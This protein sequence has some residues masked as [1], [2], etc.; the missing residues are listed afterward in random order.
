M[1]VAEVS[2]LS[3]ITITPRYVYVL[4]YNA[5]TLWKNVIASISYSSEHIG[6]SIASYSYHS[7]LLDQHYCFS[8]LSLFLF[9][10]CFST[11]IS[12]C[13]ELEGDIKFFRQI[14]F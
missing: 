3:I 14:S 4:S 8:L 12:L 5:L 6:A 13:A 7:K 9:W 2:T 10:I 1:Y 11:P